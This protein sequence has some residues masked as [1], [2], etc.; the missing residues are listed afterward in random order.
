MEARPRRRIANH[1]Q[2]A[3]EA[4]IH[5]PDYFP[6]ISQ[7]Y[8]RHVAYTL[9][10]D[11]AEDVLADYF[12]VRQLLSHRR[13]NEKLGLELLT[14]EMQHIQPGTNRTGCMCTRVVL[15]FFTASLWRR[16]KP[17]G[18]EESI[19][20][21]FKQVQGYLQYLQHGSGVPPQPVVPIPQAGIL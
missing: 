2:A 1:L 20:D 3:Q 4:P 17:P 16:E 7:M 12:K 8:N 18:D 19:E 21:I 6:S 15:S 9:A 10:V 5:T 13:C 14:K 11:K